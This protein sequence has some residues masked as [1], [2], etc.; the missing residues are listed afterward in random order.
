MSSLLDIRRTAA[1]LGIDVVSASLSP[2]SLDE[3]FM[4][5]AFEAVAED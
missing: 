4:G 5:T 1:A 2:P 3:V